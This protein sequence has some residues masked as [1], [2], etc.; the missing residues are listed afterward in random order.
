MSPCITC[1]KPLKKASSRH[2]CKH[3]IWCGI[4][5]RVQLLYRSRTCAQCN[6]DLLC[7]TTKSS[8]ARAHTEHIPY[9]VYPSAIPYRVYSLYCACRGTRIRTGTTCF[10]RTAANRYLI[11]RGVKMNYAG[12]V[13]VEES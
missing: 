3:G 7:F 12:M 10:R 9:R 8:F 13:V 5:G 4:P 1:K 11:P 2:K 6:M